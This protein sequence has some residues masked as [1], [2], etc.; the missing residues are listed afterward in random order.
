M[1]PAKY[2]SQMM[3]VWFLAT[4]TG[5]A[6][7]GWTTKLNAPLGDAAY[8]TLQAVVAVAAGLA[9]MVAGRKIRALMGGVK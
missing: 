9:F 5:N 2:A 7:N 6:L 3:G 4:S 8:Y 1:A